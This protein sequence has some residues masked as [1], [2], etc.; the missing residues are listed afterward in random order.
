MKIGL[1]IEQAVLGC[2]YCLPIIFFYSCF[3]VEDSGPQYPEIG[4]VA[5]LPDQSG[6]IAM[7]DKKSTGW[8]GDIPARTHYA[9]YKLSLQGKIL[10]TIY[11]PSSNEY[12]EPPLYFSV[13]GNSFIYADYFYI[14]NYSIVSKKGVYIDSSSLENTTKL[15][16]ASP[17]N[18]YVLIEQRKNTGSDAI[19]YKIEEV[20]NSKTRII[21]TIQS[22]L[23]FA[24]WVSNDR[25]AVVNYLTNNSSNLIV[26]DTL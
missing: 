9:F 1:R 2:L 11:E 4:D 13:D 20:R 14:F 21:S 12:Y 19:L 10:E 3:W 23:S 16:T 15:V 18:R 24:L 7:A 8:V 5:W 25:I 26:Y 22:L 6:F 17:D